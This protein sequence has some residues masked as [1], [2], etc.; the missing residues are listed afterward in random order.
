[1]IDKL[2]L[3]NAIEKIEQEKLVHD[4]KFAGNDVHKDCLPRFETTLTKLR[5][6]LE[7]LESSDRI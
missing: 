6:E 4:S 7:K 1:M 3:K 5:N 2:Y